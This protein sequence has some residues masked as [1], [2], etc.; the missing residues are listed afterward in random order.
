MIRKRILITLTQIAVVAV[1]LTVN[2]LAGSAG[3]A[4]RSPFSIALSIALGM[5]VV[6]EIISCVRISDSTA[7]TVF[8]A[9]FLFFYYITSED[10][11][12]DFSQ[13]QAFSIVVETVN[14]ACALGVLL[15]VLSFTDYTYHTELKKKF[16]TVG[17]TVAVVSALV[18]MI[19]IPSGLQYLSFFAFLVLA[20]AA[21]VTMYRRIFR[22]NTDDNTFYLTITIAYLLVSSALCGILKSAG[23]IPGAPGSPSVH[24][25][26]IILCFIAIYVSFTLRTERN[27]LKASEYKLQAEK[28]RSK[29]LRDQINPHFIFNSLT[30]V[31]SMYHNSTD[32][33]DYCLNLFSKTLRANIESINVDLVSFDDELDNIDNYITL[34][35]LRR[36]DK[37]IQLT[38]NIEYSDFYVPILSLQVFV[39]NAVR[40]ARTDERGDGFIEI[41]SYMKDDCVYIEVNDNGVGFDPEKIA[42]NSCGIRNS[43]ERFKLLLNAETLIDSAPGQGTRVRICIDENMRGG[44]GKQYEYPDRR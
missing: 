15:S 27:A 39:E 21:T 2:I 8:L 6:I 18:Y 36:K 40:Y 9:V 23:S 10:S 24:I 25:F 1:S 31:K 35:N 4:E 44:W 7:H 17:I 37:K 20:A 29:I 33:G 5:I 16:M 12:I 42:E 43:R 13:T 11:V 30:T 34:E 28:M 26:L 38:Y 41:R 3:T 22:K 32:D 19:L 14:Y